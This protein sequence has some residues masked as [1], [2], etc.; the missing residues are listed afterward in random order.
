MSRDDEFTLKVEVGERVGWGCGGRILCKAFPKAL[1]LGGT[2]LE[3]ESE[4]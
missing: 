3:Y 4:S 1:G 2:L